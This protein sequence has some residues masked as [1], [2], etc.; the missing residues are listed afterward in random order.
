[1]Q[2]L[3]ALAVHSAWNRRATLSL[4]VLAIALSV[5]LLLGVERLRENIRAGFE[6]SVSGADLIVGAR[7]SPLQLMLYSVFR[8]GE[9]TH[10]ME[11]TS[12]QA[13]AANPAVAWSIP[14]SLGDS[15]H[16]YPVLGTT[17]DYFAHFRYGD[18]RTLKLAEGRPFDGV[19]DAV[20]GA[21]VAEA[22]DY[23][24]GSRITLSHGGG[25][26]DLAEHADKPFIV[27][28]ILARTGTPVDRTVHISLEAME[29][30][31]LD[32]QG[33]A[34]IPGMS[35]PAEYVKKFDLTPKTVTAVIL[36]L[37]S[38]AAVFS[39]QRYINSYHAE[40]LMAVLPGVAL[41]QLWQVVGI[42][43]KALLAVSAL[44]VVVGLAG[45]VAVVLAGLNERRR[46]L[47]VLRSVGAHPRDILALLT[48]DGLGL[49]LAGSGLGFLLLTT[50]SLVLG[51]LIES[52]FGL[53]LA[54]GMPTMEE[55]YL[56]A[57]VVFV[58]LVASLLPGWRAYRISL[59]D[60]LTPRS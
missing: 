43:E 48:L 56:L 17:K 24:L 31:H 45:L 26:T 49:T 7:G 27:V 5:C 1:M 60:G 28:G 32:W 44:V 25:G 40:P 52:R 22:L 20:L 11:W 46:E 2:H 3:I 6:Q 51:P 8:I 12:V 34:P 39:V 9:A 21:E 55:L 36:G 16:G 38:R 29:A 50:L 58:G 18:A 47:A 35:I 15:H 59:A 54:A 19:F 13:L 33:G 10:N 14:I 57:G 30:I 53:S 23:K 42:G 4:T 41:S 37:K